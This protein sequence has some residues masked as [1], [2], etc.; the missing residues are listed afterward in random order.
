ML[1]R[2]RILEDFRAKG[3]A[4]QYFLEFQLRVLPAR[5]AER[6][7]A[8][9]M[10]GTRNAQGELTRVVE[11]GRN[12][13]VKTAKGEEI[14]L[15]ITSDTNIEGAADRTRLALGMKA[16]VLYKEPEDFN[17]ALGYDVIELEVVPR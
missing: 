12:L 17:P 6:V 14:R 13:T 10:W 3:I 5:G 16:R 11:A 8:G 2:S 15:R 7:I 9:R 4:G 1:F